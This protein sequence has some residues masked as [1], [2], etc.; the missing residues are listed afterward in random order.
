MLILNAIF[1]IF[2]LLLLGNILKRIQITNDT[3]LKTS[4]KLIYYIFF[5]VMLFWKIGKA[6]PDPI[7]GIASYFS[8][9][10]AAI[11]A[12]II[13][14]LLS[15]V[16]IKVFK[17]SN[18]QA[19]AFSQACYRFNTYIGMAVVMNALGEEGIRYFGIII[20]FTIPLVNVMAVSTLIWF[21]GKKQ[22]IWHHTIRL[23]KALV[24]NPLIIGCV[25]G[26]LFSKTKMAFPLFIDNT[27][28]LLTAVTMPLALISIGG[29]LTMKGLKQNL[30]PAFVAT[31]L[32]GIALPIIGYT[33]LVLLNI[34]GIP[35]KA[36]LIFFALPTSTTI[37]VLSAQL[38]SDTQMASAAIMLTTLFSFISLSIALII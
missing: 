13:I 12:V 33:L 8:V 1:P 22:S 35:F 25:A 24:S 3:F 31:V 4:D 27:F 20:G 6:A 5:P 21:S 15:L 19:G 7:S 38:D 9:C 11:L 30:L 29:S 32:K 23:L 34:T 28:S 10:L 26:I 18:F 37:Y 14:Y 2:I 17:T 16:A 36:G